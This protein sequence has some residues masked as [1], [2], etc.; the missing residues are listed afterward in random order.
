[1]IALERTQYI[2]DTLK[3]NKIVL[4]SELSKDIEV[5]EETIRRDL[6]KL[7]KQELIWRV[8]GGAYLREGIGNETSIKVREQIYQEE[9]ALISK[10]CLKLIH[11]QDSI[12]L[13]CSTTA[14]YIAKEL[15]NSTIKVTV[16]TNSLSVANELAG[17][18]TIRLILLG[19]ELNNITNSFVGDHALKSLENYH[20]DKAFISSAGISVSAGLSDYTCEEAYMHKK[21]IKQSDKCYFAADITKIGRSAVNIIG[22]LDEIDGLIINEPIH[23][24]DNIL[25]KELDRL[26]KDII[27]C[28]RISE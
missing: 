9:K 23:K 10:Q 4:V 1:M 17:T 2:L 28:K 27:T 21:M 24:K 15:K 8:H 5:T 19:G 25:K 20:A 12:I 16:I 18:D 14:I 13:D 11:D 26:K 22:K 3:K 7:E 6:E